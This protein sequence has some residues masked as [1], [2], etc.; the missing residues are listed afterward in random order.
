LRR[1]EWEGQSVVGS[2]NP[3]AIAEFKALAPQVE[4]SILFGS[5]HID[6]IQLARSLK[7][8]YVHPCWERLPNPSS[9]LTSE[10]IAR[11]RQA[12]LGIICWHEERP[13]EI[14]AL[15]QV[16]IDGICSDA[17]ELLLGN[18]P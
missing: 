11:V 4:T 14:A 17:P 7:A 10:W 13:A 18:R 5:T 8:S 16:G 2:F 12:D 3:D 15:Q 9:L 6:A 1:Y